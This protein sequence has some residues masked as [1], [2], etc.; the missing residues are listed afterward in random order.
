MTRLGALRGRLQ[1]LFSGA[2]P[3]AAVAASAV[4]G[5]QHSSVL[6][7]AFAGV[8]SIV[9]V[10]VGVP[11]LIR[12]RYPVARV[13]AQVQARAELALFVPGLHLFIY[14]LTM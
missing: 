12:W 10:A 7:A 4:A 9:A 8:T 1:S 14:A 3:A 13:D 5:A 2:A 11:R 6:G